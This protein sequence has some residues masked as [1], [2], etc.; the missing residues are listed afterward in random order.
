M[1][2]ALSHQAYREFRFYFD[3]IV[4]RKPDGIGWNEWLEARDLLP[5]QADL[6]PWLDGLC[7]IPIPATMTKDGIPAEFV[8]SPDLLETIDDMPEST[9]ANAQEL[10][11]YVYQ[12]AGTAD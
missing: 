9:F 8:F 4:R 10:I 12:T 3:A 5:Y 1:R 7:R 6:A 2:Y 11:D